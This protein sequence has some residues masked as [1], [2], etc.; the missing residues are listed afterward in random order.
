MFS[1]DI[2]VVRNNSE[3]AS[4]PLKGLK[5]ELYSKRSEMMFPEI[6]EKEKEY[7]IVRIKLSYQ[8]AIDSY[9]EWETCYLV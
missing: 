7:T 8:I 3:L 5:N 6:C 9:Y 2:V 4:Q 1:S